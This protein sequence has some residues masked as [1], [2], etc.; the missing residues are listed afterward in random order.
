MRGYDQSAT[1]T[2]SVPVF[3]GFVDWL[4]LDV[5]HENLPVHHQHRRPA[6]V[7]APVLRRRGRVDI[8][9][10][11]LRPVVLDPLLTV[12]IDNR[13]EVTTTLLAILVSVTG[14][15]PVVVE[16]LLEDDPH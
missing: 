2:S 14:V 12:P 8:D 10:L 1:T 13:H 7:F 11:Y 9:N 3:P 16:S 6:I 4:H 5:P 15:G